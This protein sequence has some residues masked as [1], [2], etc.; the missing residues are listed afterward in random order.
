MMPHDL[1]GIRVATRGVGQSVACCR[2]HRPAR[3]CG[4][5]GQRRTGSNCV[6]KSQDMPFGAFQVG[7]ATLGA[8]DTWQTS[9]NDDQGPVVG[10][11]L[12]RGR[13]EVGELSPAGEQEMWVALSGLT[14]PSE[15]TEA[16]H[17]FPYS[18]CVEVGAAAGI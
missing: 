4:G 1:N 3:R 15:I 2:A 12:L 11:V 6:E 8:P 9:Q 7:H 13:S 14:P 17:G 18:Y 5:F 10:H 16:A